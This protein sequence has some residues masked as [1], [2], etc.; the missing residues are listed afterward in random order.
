ML[1]GLVCVLLAC[2]AGLSYAPAGGHCLEFAVGLFGADP[3]RATTLQDV[4]ARIRFLV[5]VEGALYDAVREAHPDTLVA[6]LGVPGKGRRYVPE[7]SEHAAA[8]EAEGG[9][10]PGVG[11]TKTAADDPATDGDGDKI[12]GIDRLWFIVGAAAVVVCVLVAAA[13]IVRSRRSRSREAIA[14]EEPNPAQ[15]EILPGSYVPGFS[16]PTAA[17][18]GHLEKSDSVKSGDS[19]SD[20]KRPQTMVESSLVTTDTG[21]VAA[22]VTTKG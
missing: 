21:D 17:A 3:S 8:G 15:G 2:P 16:I 14:E 18:P 7:G 22:V 5:D 13:L 6:G 4:A 1:A 10:E 11:A 20:S 19:A 12:W 9:D